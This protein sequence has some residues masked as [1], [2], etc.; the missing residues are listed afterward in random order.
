MAQPTSSQ[1]HIDAAL[2]NIA[3][4][5]SNASYIADT[6]FPPVGVDKQ[7][8]YYYT[9]AKDFW[10]RNHV[11]RRGPGGV[12]PEAGL[13]LST[14]QYY[15]QN[16]GLSFPIPNE[17]IRNQD[18]A[19]DIERTGAEFLADQFALDREIALAAKIFGASAW[20]SSTALTGTTQWSD[21]ENSNPLSDVATAVQTVMKATGRKPNVCVMGQE[22]FDKASRHP[23]LLDIY[24]YT[25][26]GILNEAEV[27]RAFRVDKIIVGSSVYNSS[28]EG[29]TFSGSF[30]W[31][32]NCVF[33]YVAAA[34]GLRVPS[35]GYTFLWDQNGFTV[36]VRRVEDEWRNRIGLLA[37]SAFD[38]KVTASDC[39][40]E[41]TTVVA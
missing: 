1:V 11:E 4:A 23:D 7:S 2:S 25:T 26:Q 10:F 36:P 19:I 31:G 8:D 30:I 22:V 14:T 5:Y 37:D 38:Q 27:A 32:K 20:G 3:I 17:T 33:M 24:K 21:Y 34:P 13:T 9:W 16:R 18:A 39:G 6:L 41:I 35:A 12:Y 28:P 15:C 40:Y 29:I